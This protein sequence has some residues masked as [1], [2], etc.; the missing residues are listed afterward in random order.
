MSENKEI[1]I[2]VLR[3]YWLK[4]PKEGEPAIRVRAGT[5]LPAPLDEKTL[6]F[7][8][9]GIIRRHSPE[10]KAAEEAK[11]AKEK[12]DLIQKATGKK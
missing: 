4:N 12:A 2:E 1:Q 11:K 8:E 3:D 5:I 7:I 6:G 9:D 10:Q